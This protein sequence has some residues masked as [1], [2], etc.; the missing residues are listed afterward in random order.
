[1]F[2]SASDI[3][4]IIAAGEITA[5]LPSQSEK[6][7]ENVTKYFLDSLLNYMVSEVCVDLSHFCT[8]VQL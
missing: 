2:I 6:P 3:G 8:L 1:M 4:G 5:I 7:P